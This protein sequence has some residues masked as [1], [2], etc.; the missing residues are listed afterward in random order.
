MQEVTG[1]NPGGT[2]NRTIG[3]FGEITPTVL[4][5]LGSVQFCSAH[6]FGRNEI[7]YYKVFVED[8][9]SF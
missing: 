9:Y 2:N 1:S 8:M 4:G 3:L 7:N 6:N 5:K